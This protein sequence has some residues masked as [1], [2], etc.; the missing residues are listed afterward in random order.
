MDN[1]TKFIEYC[2]RGQLNKVLSMMQ[3]NNIY[4]V[5]AIQKCN[6]HF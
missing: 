2:Q 4:V 6:L 1:K 3:D 5:C